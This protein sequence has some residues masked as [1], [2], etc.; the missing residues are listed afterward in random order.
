MTGNILP[1][2][3]RTGQAID[4]AKRQESLNPFL[5]VSHGQLSVA[6]FAAGRFADSIAASER[7]IEL[8]PDNV[9][10]LTGLAF[11]YLADGQ[12]ESSER[13][14]QR[15]PAEFIFRTIAEGLVAARKGERGVAAR[16]VAAIRAQLGD[17]ASYQFAQIAAQSADVDGAFESLE[18]AIRIRD[19][20]LNQTMR[21]PFLVPLRKDKRFATILKRLDFPIIDPA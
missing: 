20:G 14:I 9:G 4:I 21:D 18:A 3:A 8:S 2:I 15:L 10:E 6:Y 7:A 16:K 17:L 19:P 11:S 5:P 12:V 1:W 13:A